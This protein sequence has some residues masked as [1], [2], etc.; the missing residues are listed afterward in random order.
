MRTAIVLVIFAAVFIGLTVSSYRQD[1]A[2]IDEPQHL[3]FGY[4]ALKLRDY[5]LDIEHPPFLRM[6]AALPLLAM[7]DV[8]FDT[9]TV[10]WSSVKP[11][12]LSHKFLYMENDADHLL[13]RARFMI[14]L[15]GVLLGV[16][17]FY[18]ARELFGFWQATIVLG[19]FSFEPTLLAHFALV[20][21]DAGVTCFIFGTMYFLWRTIKRLS[22]WNLI[23][24][25]VFFALAQVSKF[26]AL[27]LIPV[28][29]AFLAVHAHRERKW[30]A[31]LGIALALAVVSYLAIWAAY[32][33]RYAP[34]PQG[35]GLD[36]IV[37]GP[38]AHERLPTLTAMLDWVDD[39]RLLPNVY[40][41]GFA[42]SQA[43]AQDRTAYLLGGIRFTGWWYYFPVALLVKTPVSLIVL[44]IA[45]FA[46]CGAKRTEADLYILFPLVIYLGVSMMAQM[47]VGVR[48]ILP[49]YPFALMLAGKAV[50]EILASRRKLLRAGLG[51][52]CLLQAAE[53]TAA[54]PHHLAFFNCLV[55]GPKNGYRYLADS[56][57]DWGQDLKRLKNWMDANGVDHINLSYFGSADPGYYGINCTYLLGSP[58]HAKEK[59]Q[60]LALPGLVAVSI[61]NLTGVGLNGNPFYKPLL[62]AKP[63]AVIRSSILVYRVEKPWW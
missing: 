54:H 5:R 28:T 35:S 9:N 24:L 50:S 32:G 59:I 26:S 47:N 11:W 43:A 6:W 29:A 25:I 49:I 53:V 27:V 57:L 55:G 38:K 1:S 37:S 23:G 34:A 15:L 51:G 45:G 46:L 58:F 7:S 39:H 10:F 61:N 36:R 3:T 18:W 20:T 16:V 42:V 56:N 33:F 40:T 22:L 12:Q 2:T 13:N 14:V 44:V 31:A 8:R 19:L 52:L 62:N 48:H 30:K 21:T 41:Q 63:V 60:D 17:L 4:A